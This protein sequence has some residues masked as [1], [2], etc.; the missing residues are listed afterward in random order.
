MWTI[1]F[2]GAASIIS[3]SAKWAGI[4]IA[5]F[6]GGWRKEKKIAEKGIEH[7]KRALEID[8]SVEAMSPA[9]RAKWLRGGD[10]D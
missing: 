4:G 9:D 6:A 3:A 1:I 8:E 2:K 7:A 10:R 5:F